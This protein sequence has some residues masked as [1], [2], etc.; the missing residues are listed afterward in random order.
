MADQKLQSFPFLVVQASLVQSETLC[1]SLPGLLSEKVHIFSATHWHSGAIWHN[2]GT[3]VLIGQDYPNYA[4]C[5]CLPQQSPS[6]ATLP[7]WSLAQTLSCCSN[8]AS[9]CKF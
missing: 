5:C 8:I 4:C 3:Q 6:S 9:G 2:T 1:I 7:R